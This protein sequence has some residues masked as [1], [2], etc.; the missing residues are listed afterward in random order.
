VLALALSPHGVLYL[1]PDPDPDAALAVAADVASRIERAFSDDPGEGLLHLGAVEVDVA[2]PPT[3]AY[4]RDLGRDFVT[5][6]RA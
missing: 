1:E 2:L 3:L 4:F 6:L 5:A